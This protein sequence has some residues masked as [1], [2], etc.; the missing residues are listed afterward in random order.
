FVLQSNATANKFLQGALGLTPQRARAIAAEVTDLAEG[1]AFVKASTQ[2]R[3]E[4]V[5]ELQLRQFWRDS[6]SL[7]QLP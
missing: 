5:T 7:A 3:R 6:G 2:G 4:G 1:R